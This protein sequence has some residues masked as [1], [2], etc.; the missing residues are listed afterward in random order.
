MVKSVDVYISVE[1]WNELRIPMDEIPVH[2]KNLGPSVKQLIDTF[3]SN[4]SL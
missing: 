1:D 4:L 2:E 3:L